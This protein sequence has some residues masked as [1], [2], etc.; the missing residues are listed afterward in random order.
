MCV[1]LQQRIMEEGE[2]T[3]EDVIPLKLP[4]SSTQCSRRRHCIREE[5]YNLPLT[6]T[7]FLLTYTTHILRERKKTAIYSRGI[8]E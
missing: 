8:K 1:E 6:T 7:Y 2:K 4:Y 3:T 5:M